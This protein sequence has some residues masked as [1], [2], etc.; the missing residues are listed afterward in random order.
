M[1][2]NFLL[3]AVT[4]LMAASCQKPLQ[5]NKFEHDRL[6]NEVGLM[7][8]VV[9]CTP[10]TLSGTITTN[11]TL[12]TGKTYVLDG[13]V[14]VKNATLTI[15]P[16]TLILGKS[17]VASGLVIDKTAQIN[18]VG[19]DTSP[20]IFTS[21]KTPGTRAPGDWLGVFIMGNAPN[22]QG[23]A[24]GFSIE[25]NNYTA[26]GTS[27]ASSQGS[28]EYVQVHFAGKGSSTGDIL[29]ESSLVLG[30]IG[31]GMIIKNIQITN[32]LNDGLG[33]WGG[34]VKLKQIFSYKSQRWEFPISQGYRG[35]MQSLFAFKD[36]VTTAATN[37]SVMDITN[38]LVGSDNAPYTYPTISNATLLGGT[39]CEGSD[40]DYNRGIEIRRNGSAKIYNSVIEGFD[41]FGF[42]L[43]GSNIIAKTKTGTDQLIFSYN[44]LHDSGTPSY[45]QDFTSPHSTWAAADGCRFNVS[46]TMQNWIEGTAGVACQQDG[47]QFSLTATGYYKNN[48]CSNKCN[49]FPNLYI[50]EATVDLEE[51]EYGMLSGFDQ[52]QFRGALQSSTDTWLKNTWVDFCMLTRN[53][54]E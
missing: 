36:N 34:E 22:N 32:S 44:T 20:I 25:G 14:D 24:L 9:D 27:S 2:R 21:D 50:N 15:Q 28:F 37:V 5:D 4:V 52:P 38:N 46:G 19:T 3:L 17:S 35:N 49:A 11:T 13:V 39:Y 40:I 48:L 16:G 29:T 53:Y 8:I 10:I 30:S 43:N 23:N 1:K 18:A 31:N 51:P 12:L 47:N 26:G 7:N 54:C 6:G 33:I 45:S 41:D 42:F